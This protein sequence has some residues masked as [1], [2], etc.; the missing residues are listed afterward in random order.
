[1]AAKAPIRLPVFD[2]RLIDD[3][4]PLRHESLTPEMLRAISECAVRVIFSKA[5]DKEIAELAA[6]LKAKPDKIRPVVH[7]LSSLFWECAKAR[8]HSDSFDQAMTQLGFSR[9]ECTTVLGEYYG[10][11]AEG[12]A[13]ATQAHGMALPQFRHLDWRID[14]EVGRRTLSA[15][16]RPNFLLRLDLSE[17]GGGKSQAGGVLS[18]VHLQSDVPT[19]RHLLAQLEA[20]VAEE[21]S[22]HARR[23]Q[24]YIR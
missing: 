2:K 15:D 7:A 18:S 1:M 19:M 3:L 17:G 9:P 10:A 16:A 11:H 23:F 4:A 21:R 20:A 22:V 6:S 5:G 24:R 8:V 14:V 12:I 13:E